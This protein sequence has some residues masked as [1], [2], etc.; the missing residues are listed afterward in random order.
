VTTAEHPHLLGLDI[1][2]AAVDGDAS[3]GEAHAAGG[4]LGTRT[5]DRD[6]SGS[7]ATASAGSKRLVQGVEAALAAA[8]VERL[9]GAVLAMRYPVVD[10]FAIGLADAFYEL[11]LGKGQPVARALRW[12]CPGP[13]PPDPPTPGAPG[14]ADRHPGAVRPSRRRPA[15]AATAG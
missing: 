1:P 3:A 5:R 10:E 2:A 8:L 13:P 4:D 7:S 12:P 11:A 9:D 15:A 14:A 6:A